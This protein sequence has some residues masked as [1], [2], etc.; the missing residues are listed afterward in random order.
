VQGYAVAP[1][2]PVLCGVRNFTAYEHGTL[3]KTPFED[4]PVGRLCAIGFREA[5][6]TFVTNTDVLPSAHRLGLRDDQLVLLPHAIDSERLLQYGREHEHLR[7]RDA[8]TVTFL[9]PA[10]QDWVD[11]DPSWTKGNDNALH[12]LAILCNEGV[13]CRIVLAEW[14]RDIDATRRLI[15][16]LGLGDH[17]EWLPPLYK[18]SLWDAY[19]GAHAVL[20]QFVLEAIGGVAFEAMA[21]GRRVLTALDVEA[22]AGFFGEAPPLL[23]CKEPEELAAAMRLVA[24]DPLDAARR[25]DAAREWFARYHSSDR[26]VD[27]QLEAYGRVLD[28]TAQ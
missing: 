21:L 27:L 9:A 15:D 17:V 25:G 16:E 11:R 20:D 23:A 19:I 13:P 22:A 12:A 5:P 14:G 4:T 28:G 7:P 8:G 18:R 1:I 6:I 10:R 24:E 3:R 26:I 2:I